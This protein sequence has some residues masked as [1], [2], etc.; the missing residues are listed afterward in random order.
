M[1]G[2]KDIRLLK[3]MSK[4]ISY[5]LK[6]ASYL[7]DETF[8]ELSKYK[9]LYWIELED[10]RELIEKLISENSPG[11]KTKAEDK[12]N[13]GD[14]EKEDKENVEDKEST[15]DKANTEG[16]ISAEN[17]TD[18]KIKVSE[19]G[20]INAEDKINTGSLGNGEE[21][22]GVEDNENGPVM[23]FDSVVKYLKSQDFID[24]QWV[25]VYS[26]KTPLQDKKNFEIK[27]YE[28]KDP[29]AAHK[30]YISFGDA[31]ITHS[32]RKEKG[33]VV[34]DVEEC[35]NYILN[36]RHILELD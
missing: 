8:N 19:K 35:F 11:N 6:A 33:E 12:E 27:Y 17:K 9:G 3:E 1:L 28:Y 32:I 10:Q 23:L 30:S 36:L 4:A 20:K 21:K 24:H 14:N 25:R 26:A 34:G 18:V 5:Y 7:S 2:E 16:V 15:E 29:Y 22:E 13:I 31:A